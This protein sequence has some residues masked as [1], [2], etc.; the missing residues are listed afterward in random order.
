MSID[1]NVVRSV[2]DDWRPVEGY[3]GLYEVSAGGQ[4]RAISPRR[5]NGVLVG[6][7]DRKGYRRVLL[8]LA[9]VRKRHIL[10][11]VVCTA[12][13]G[14]CPEG[15]V[16]AHLDGNLSN[17]RADNLRWVTRSENEQ[18]KANHGTKLSGT[19]HPRAKLTQAQV[20]EVRQ[21]RSVGTTERN[22]ARSFSISPSHVHRIIN[23][24]TGHE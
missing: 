6:D 8:S 13:H 21:L 9:G 15:H 10:H 16:A 4:V 23:G 14:T 2:P 22:I 5:G 7:A 3:R 17:N 12:F 18:H 11:R 20:E 1:P 24:E 19:A